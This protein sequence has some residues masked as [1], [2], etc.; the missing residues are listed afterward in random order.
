MILYFL[1]NPI[2]ISVTSNIT[3]SASLGYSQS[4]VYLHV[5]KIFIY[6][7]LVN[8]LKL[9]D[10]QGHLHSKNRVIKQGKFISNDKLILA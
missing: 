1:F 9:L 4:Q 7:A 5:T 2:G 8:S 3:R 10:S 6:Y